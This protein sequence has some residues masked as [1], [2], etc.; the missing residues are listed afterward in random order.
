MGILHLLSYL[1]GII[2]FIFIVLCLA[3]GL[4]WIAEQI[5]E[6]SRLA[7]VVGERMLWGVVV[8]HIVLFFDGLPPWHLLFSIFCHLVYSRNITTKWP[9]IQLTSPAFILSC[10][11]VFIDHFLWFN[12][13]SRQSELV[14]QRSRAHGYRGAGSYGKNRGL[15]S[16]VRDRGFGEVTTFFALCVW[17]VPLF[18]FLGLSANDNTLPVQI[19]T[20]ATPKPGSHLAGQRT[21]LLRRILSPVL[22]LLPNSWQRKR[23]KEGLIAPPSPSPYSAYASTP[24][25]PY[26]PQNVPFS[27]PPALASPRLSGSWTG[28]SSGRA[29]PS[30]GNVGL[31]IL[32]LPPKG[33]RKI[34]K[35]G[36]SGEKDE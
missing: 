31:G 21:S 7:K 25:M 36:A 18:L 15:H 20:D 22:S 14:K 27:P 28:A 11:L 16:D 3:S 30:P 10:I 4:L 19:D 33:R 12:H 5:E 24:T 2:G 13:F 9:V 8:L 1:T 34:V 26:D 32:A 6:H 35:S 23:D 29:S 17:L